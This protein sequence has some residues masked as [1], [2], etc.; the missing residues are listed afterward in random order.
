MELVNQKGQTPVDMITARGSAQ[1][2]TVQVF[3]YAQQLRAKGIDTLHPPRLLWYWYLVMPLAF[4]LA[5]GIVAE[6]LQALVG[7]YV[8]TVALVLSSVSQRALFVEVVAPRF[9]HHYGLPQLPQRRSKL[10]KLGSVVD[11]FASCDIELS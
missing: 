7:W 11:C 3:Q 9:I 2:E 6:V 4:F 1:R 8:H 5:G 10:F